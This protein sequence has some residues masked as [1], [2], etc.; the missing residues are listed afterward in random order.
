MNKN[1]IKIISGVIILG[2]VYLVV[3]SFMKK[4]A[5][6]I[7]PLKPEPN[8]PEPN[9]PE[10]KP[11]PTIDKSFPIKKGDRDSGAPLK[12]IGKVV[13]L[14]KL[15]N[16]KGYIPLADRFKGKSLIKLTEDGIF[17]SKTEEALASYINKK[18]ID[19]QADLNYLNNMI[20]PSNVSFVK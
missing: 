13:N 17:G 15:I 1:A 5:S 10:P 20:N 4:N 16:Q 19:N 2:G 11:T 14:Q 6:G 12:P 9:K 3:K 8:K 7:E 18:S